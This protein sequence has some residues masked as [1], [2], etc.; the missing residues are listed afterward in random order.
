MSCAETRRLLDAYVDNEI[1]V[2]GALDIDDHLAQCPACATARRGLRELRA[3]ARENLVSYALPEGFEA[4]LGAALRA[5]PVPERRSAPA[6]PPA[7]P[8]APLVLRRRNRS[9][10]IGFTS[11]AAAAALVAAV[12]PSLWHRGSEA[13]GEDAIFA[14][15]VRSLQAN[16]LTDVAS[17]D[18]HTVKPWF[19]GKLDYSISARDYAQAGFP[20]VGGRLDYV[21]DRPAAALVYQRARHVVN[22]FVWPA[23]N[24][25]DEPLR[26]VTH[27][28]Y[29]AYR[30]TRD[31][32][33]HSVVSDLND[34][35]L[36][37]F[38]DLVQ[39]DAEGH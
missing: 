32:M 11:A 34:A 36:R 37:A 16:H 5:Q 27:R 12:G 18:Q 14:A 17:S 28:G 29:S 25:R 23:S 20:L 3:L 33:S 4:R 26:H 9:A 10:W 22:L 8:P 24:A 35:E 13:A 6:E 15:H 30:W 1:D 2:R 7:P 19:Q 21:E 31:G 38:V 39:R